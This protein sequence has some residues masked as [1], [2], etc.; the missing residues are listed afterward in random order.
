MARKKKPEIIKIPTQEEFASNLVYSFLQEEGL[1]M[2][3]DQGETFIGVM[4]NIPE[5]NAKFTVWLCNLIRDTS[6]EE[7]S[8]PT[9]LKL[10]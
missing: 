10:N 2:N 9:N 8:S 6:F 7:L 5:I 4:L 3:L 1:T